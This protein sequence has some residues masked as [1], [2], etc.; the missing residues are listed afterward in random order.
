MTT[1][2]PLT[3]ALPPG[4]AVRSLRFARRR[5]LTLVLGVALVALAALATAGLMLGDSDL[6]PLR[7]FGAAF[8]IGDRGDLFVVQRLRLPRVQAAILVGAAFGLAGALFQ[9]T[10]RNP[11]ASPDILGIGAGASLGAVTALLA[12]GLSGFAV[13]ASAFGGATLVALAIWFFA[14]RRGLHSI[15]FVLVGVGFSYLCGS[16]LSWLL[17]RADDR[18]AASA[19]MWT[20]GSVADVRDGEIGLLLAGVLTLALVA[21]LLSRS[22]GPL[23][24]GDDNARALGVHVDAVRVGSLLTAVG[25]V[26]LATSMAGPIAF[27]AL[28]SPAIARRLLDDGTPALA[29]SAAAG[30]VLTLAADLAGQH[31]LFGVG[32]PVGIVTGLVGA[33]YLLWLLATNERRNLG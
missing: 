3:T 10:L 31:E 23:A 4:T 28:V 1:T 18:E 17:A 21:A 19:L 2:A 26:A 8:G 27:V 24:L 16:F 29:A 33:P 20:V 14:W 25:L 5:R 11:L 30:A 15:R 9:G 22:Q 13:A 32:A 7:A 6:T 12:F